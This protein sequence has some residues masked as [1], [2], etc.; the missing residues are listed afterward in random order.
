MTAIQ[1]SNELATKAGN[2]DYIIMN[3]ASI[4]EWSK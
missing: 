2:K 4:A 1:K 3:N